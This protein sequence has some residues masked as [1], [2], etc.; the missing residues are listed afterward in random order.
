MHTHTRPTIMSPILGAVLLAL[1]LI[2]VWAAVPDALLVFILLFGV[3]AELLL[4]GIMYVI[5]RRRHW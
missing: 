4:Y 2:I 1:A 5:E 3:V